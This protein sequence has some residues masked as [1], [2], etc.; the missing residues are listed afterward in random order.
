M[1]GMALIGLGGFARS[2][3]DE[4]ARALTGEGWQ[5]EAFA[6][7][8]KVLA[9]KLDPL[10]PHEG[11]WFRLA[12]VVDRA[13][14]EHAKTLPAVR[15]YLQDVGVAARDTIG[16]DVWVTPVLRCLGPGRRLVVT[17]VRFPN[18]ID[19]VRDAGG[20]LILVT[21]PG[22]AA[23]N[24]HV[25]EAAAAD[26]S[27]WDHVVVNDGTVDQLHAQVR[28]VAAFRFP[29]SIPSLV[30][31]PARGLWRDTAPLPVVTD[32]PSIYDELRDRY[33]L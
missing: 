32:G 3:K 19:A 23:V 9:H 24:G 31:P 11:T 26:E 13:G 8:L 30:P 29:G 22:V 1:T 14:W 18:E 10:L 6:D 16:S 4:S 2:G 33:R 7:R 15:A 25:S 27:L 28:A 12:E 20:V 5:R 17:D 21:R